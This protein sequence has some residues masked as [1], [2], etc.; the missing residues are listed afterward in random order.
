MRETVTG[1]SI[2]DWK[3]NPVGL[4]PETY[5]ST[6][7]DGERGF[8]SSLQISTGLIHTHTH[9]PGRLTKFFSELWIY[10]IIILF[11][12]NTIFYFFSFPHQ[13][14]VVGGGRTVT[15]DINGLILIWKL[16]WL[17]EGGIILGFCLISVVNILHIIEVA[18]E[19]VMCCVV[20]NVIECSL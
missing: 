4:F 1:Y 15:R 16:N 12:F 8:Y 9:Y 5:R 17:I 14:R 7:K 20:I 19:T 2:G 11:Y 13:T 18:D 10:F 6:Q 3:A